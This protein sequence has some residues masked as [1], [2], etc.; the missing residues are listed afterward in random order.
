MSRRHAVDALLRVYYEWR[1]NYGKLPDIAIVDWTGVPTVSEFRLFVAYL[2]RYGITATICTPDELEFRNGQM[3]AAGRAVDF[4]YKR[5][6]TTELLQRY[7][8]E[9][10]LIEA[11]QR[12]SG[13]YGQPL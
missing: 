2:A 8:L 10:P 13:L 6:L 3:W 9:H 11:A 5:V 1:G 12:R 7:G 4:V